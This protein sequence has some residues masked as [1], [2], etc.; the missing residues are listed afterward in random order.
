LASVYFFLALWMVIDPPPSGV[1]PPLPRG[2]GRFL[3]PAAQAPD[4]TT[5]FLIAGTVNALDWSS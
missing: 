3:E 1:A 2:Q 5:R 4:T